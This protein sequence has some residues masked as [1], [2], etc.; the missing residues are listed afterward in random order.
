MAEHIGFYFH[1]KGKG[2]VDMAKGKGKGGGK[3]DWQNT[4]LTMAMEKEVF[5]FIRQWRRTHALLPVSAMDI[6]TVWL[7]NLC[8][9][10]QDRL[11]K[12]AINDMKVLDSNGQWICPPQD[13]AGRVR[14]ITAHEKRSEQGHYCYTII[15]ADPA[16]LFFVMA[17][18]HAKVMNLPREAGH[19]HVKC[20]PPALHWAMAKDGKLADIP[21]RD[22]VA[23]WCPALLWEVWCQ[24]TMPD[25]ILDKPE[26]PRPGQ[27][28]GKAA[29]ET[30]RP[31]F[32]SHF[33]GGPL[34]GPLC[35]DY[36]VQPDG[37]PCWW[38]DTA[39]LKLPAN[40]A[41]V[42]R[43]AEAPDPL[44][45]VDGQ[46]FPARVARAAPCPVPPMT[47]NLT[48]DSSGMGP[49]ARSEEPVPEKYKTNWGKFFLSEEDPLFG[50]VPPGQ[51]SASGQ[52]A[53][54]G[55][56]GP[57]AFSIDRPRSEPEPE[58]AHIPFPWEI[59]KE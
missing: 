58:D 49:I 17:I 9:G 48:R 36:D 15:L 16:D 43:P 12:M 19:A 22:R 27:T 24:A 59:A 25:H 47:A 45:D 6:K 51:P 14:K 10:I 29:G 54:S 8:S 28:Y 40:T 4:G 34:V 50:P 13:R 30:I 3:A 37:T 44:A 1:N 46:T 41:A 26:R 33:S 52:T 55:Q 2:Q 53:A 31:Y 20:M 32:M 21:Y 38:Q 42:H 11:W 23:Q 56:T 18:F 5:D 7:G 57:A 35:K 39:L